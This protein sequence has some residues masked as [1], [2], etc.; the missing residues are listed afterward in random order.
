LIGVLKKKRKEKM[1]MWMVDPIILCKNHLLGEHGEIHKHLWTFL[2]R[3]KK[4]KYI[5]NNCIEPSA[6]ER[7]HNAL[8]KE[9]LRRGYN[10]KSP[11]TQPDI[12]YLPWYQQCYKVDRNKSLKELVSRCP[13]CRKNYIKR[14]IKGARFLRKI[15]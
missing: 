5:K 11:Y 3:H 9:M 1:R 14:V 7:R 15:K 4:D 13:E 10:H 12:S 6:M 8:V 2:K